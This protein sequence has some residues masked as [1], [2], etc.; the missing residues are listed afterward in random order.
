MRLGGFYS[1]ERAD[2]LEA[3]CPAL[4]RHGLSAIAAPSRLATMPDEECVAF[5]EAARGLGLVVGETGMWENLMTPDPELWRERIAWVRTLLRKADL[6]GCRCV[7]TLVGSGHPSDAP[8]AP[9][10]AMLTDAGAR[11]FRAV[12]LRIL[13]GLDLRT[14]RYGIEPWGNTFFYEPE[15]IAEFL[16]SVDHPSLGLH[17]DLVNMVDRRS[18]FDTGGLARRTFALLSDRIVGAHLKDLR[19]DFAHM[20]IKWDEVLVGDGVMDYAAY[21]GGLAELDPDLACFC[22]HLET[23]AD[24]AESF[25]RVHAA[26]DRAGVTFLPR[27][28]NEGG[29]P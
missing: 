27:A 14:T 15:A 20:V 13:D 4:D 17:L 26:A 28:P 12:V 3:L 7:I 5:G 18:Y 11:S 2:Q 23:E 25:V 22:E 19:W 1:A 8:L 21:L 16:S 24:Y 9:D 6:M 29:G 10:A